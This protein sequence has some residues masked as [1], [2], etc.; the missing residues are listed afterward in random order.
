MM[1]FEKRLLEKPHFELAAKGVFRLGRCYIFRQGV[2]GLCLWASNGK[3][4]LPTADRLTGLVAP[5]Q[6]VTVPLSNDKL[7]CI[8]I[9]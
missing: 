1:M 5:W 9:A 6:T 8:D 3:A 4:R 7:S 2:P